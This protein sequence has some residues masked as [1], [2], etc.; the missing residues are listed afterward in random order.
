MG[1]GGEVGGRWLLVVSFCGVDCASVSI[2]VVS[3]CGVI[4]AAVSIDVGVSFVGSDVSMIFCGAESDSMSMLV[5]P[6]AVST[7]DPFSFPTPLLCDCISSCFSCFT[8]E[9]SKLSFLVLSPLFRAFFLTGCDSMI[10]FPFSSNW[11]GLCA[12]EFA[13]SYQSCTVDGEVK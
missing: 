1:M 13:R 4:G 9:G 10:A 12:G 3:F 11:G 7:A 5:D 8:G 6:F 2:D